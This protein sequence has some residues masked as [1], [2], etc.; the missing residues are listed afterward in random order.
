LTVSQQR[1]DAVRDFLISQGIGKE[2]MISKG[3]GQANPF[4][5]NR[6]KEGQAKNRRVELHLQK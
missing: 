3:Y 4:A 6:T 2:L 5:D 1:A